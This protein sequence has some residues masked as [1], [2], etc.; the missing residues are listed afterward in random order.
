[1]KKPSFPHSR[2]SFTL[3]EMVTAIAILALLL[4]LLFG[5]LDSAS[6][7]VDS[8]EKGGDSA[9]QAKQVLDRIGLDIAGMVNRSDVDQ[10]YY[11]P[12]INTGNDKM[13]FYSEA[14]GYSS[15]SAT[16][17]NSVSL[18]GYRIE[19]NPNLA[20][21]QPVLQRLSYGLA[22]DG[23]AG[24]VMQFL[25]FPAGTIPITYSPATAGTI[26]GATWTSIVGS[27][28]DADNGLSP[29]Y[30]DEISSQVFR[31]EICFQNQG[32]NSATSPQFT[33]YP[34]FT[35]NAPTAAAIANS[36]NCA[37]A[38]IVAIAV[39][40]S[41][42]RQLISKAS[43]WTALQQALPDLSGNINTSASG[44]PILMDSLWNSALANSATIQSLE[45]QGVPASATA[46]VRV[47]QRYYPLT[48]PTWNQL[49]TGGMGR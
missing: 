22:L 39:L 44:Q 25:T 34:P 7:L 38:I 24:T 43:A 14:L 21:P 18:I 47:Y 12:G 13:F 4:V 15:T 16:T 10:F 30:Y 26:S 17:T 48:G 19:N 49:P 2:Q 42:S 3:V 9:I 40:D 35:N 11:Q 28:G 6:R 8:A 46:Q 33:S 45:S 31:M 5:M 37:S 27:T 41:K 23:P 29:Q 20:P 32:P 36:A 1:V